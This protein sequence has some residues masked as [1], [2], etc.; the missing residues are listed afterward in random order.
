MKHLCCT[1]FKDCF[2]V[3]ECFTTIHNDMKNIVNR[4]SPSTT[5]ESVSCASQ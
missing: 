3:E 5:E 1:P 4:I 2:S